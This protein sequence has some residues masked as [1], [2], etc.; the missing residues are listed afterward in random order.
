LILQVIFPKVIAK[1]FEVGRASP[2]EEEDT[3]RSRIEK[4]RN[5]I[6]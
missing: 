1:P 2:P 4:V 5:I 3:A 6:I